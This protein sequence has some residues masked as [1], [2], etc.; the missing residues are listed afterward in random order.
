VLAAVCHG[1]GKF[2]VGQEMSYSIELHKLNAFTYARSNAARI[3]S[4]LFAQRCGQL[5]EQNG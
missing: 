1:I 2:F 4:S 5:L 3:I